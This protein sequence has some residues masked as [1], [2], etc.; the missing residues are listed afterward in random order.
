V[1]ALVSALLLPAAAAAAVPA[2]V[3]KGLDYLHT[4]QRADGGFSYSGAHGSAS[5]TPWVMLAIAAGNNGPSIWRVAGRSPVTFLQD[6]DLASA[7]KNSGNVPE[8]YALCILAYLAANRTDLLSSAGTAQIDLVGKL[9]SYQS[10]DNG[11]YSPATPPTIAAST[12]TTAWAVLGLIAAHRSGPPVS[13]AVAWLQTPANNNG[14]GGGPNADGGFGSQPNY[15]SSTTITSLVAQA[16]VA[17]KVSPADKVVQGAAGFLETMQ[18]S[19]GGFQDTQ[20][21]FANAPSTAWAIEGLRAAG[22][23]PHKLVKGGHTPYTFLASLR[24]KNGLYY[25]FP[26]DIGDVMGATVQASIALSGATLPIYL[27]HNVATH[28]DPMF[29]RGTV[30]PKNG[31]RFAS[32]TVLVQ[33][34]YHDNV[35]GTGAKAAAISVTV[36]GKSKTKAAHITTSHLRLQLT[37]LANGSHTFVITVHDWAGNDVRIQRSFRVAVPTGGGSTGGGTHPGGSTGGSSGSSSGSSSG[38]TVHTTTPTPKATISPAQSVSPGVTLTPTPSS[39]FPS[40]LASPSPSASVTGQVAG[41]SGSGG[42]GHTAAVV[43]TLA[44][45]VPLGFAGSW[46][47]RRRLLSVMDGATRGEI[48]SPDS[49]VWQRFWKSSGG[50][51]PA[52][53]GE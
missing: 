17:A 51:P 42:G 43:G 28:F 2:G 38:G 14:S 52:G 33:A 15:Q 18:L 10:L 41:S 13:S 24:Q 40:S 30:G 39:P 31:A 6:T 4:R 20:A 7:A 35:N 22:S 3:T 34:A 8:F 49:S 46:L 50:S 25:E 26:N 44:V 36:D 27:A 23:D 37:K 47:V 19:D 21:G 9:E 12:E 5:D 32:H 48:L 1:L 16:L 45:L 11:Y 29:A 53:S